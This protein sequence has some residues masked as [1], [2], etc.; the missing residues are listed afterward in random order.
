MGERGKSMGKG[1]L[2]LIGCYEEGG[3]ADFAS[4]RSV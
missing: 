4:D 1:C 2:S 3:F